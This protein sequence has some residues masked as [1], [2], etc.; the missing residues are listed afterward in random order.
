MKNKKDKGMMGIGTLIIFIATILVAA[1]A[2]AV[3]VATS[4]S[5]QQRSLMT[6]SQA[7]EG[8]A[9]GVEAIS[10]MATDGSSGADLEH[11]EVLA[12]LQAGSDAL[13]LNNTVL[14]MDTQSNSLSLSYAGGADAAGDDGPAV[15][16]QHYNITYVKMGPDYKA[17]YISRGDI[18]KMKFNCASCSSTA[19]TGGIAENKKVRLKIVP[20]IG[21]ST[22]IEFTTPDVITDSRVSL[23]P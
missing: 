7:E 17:N 16:T 18:V 1:V 10:V 9:T 19:T 22:Q 15:D 8:I 11:F 21:T 3:L 6:G 13:N 4:S 12:R 5:L 14:I 23:W 2:A 20:R